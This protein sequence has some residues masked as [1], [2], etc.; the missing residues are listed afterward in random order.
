LLGGV[1][2]YLTNGAVREIANVH[3]VTVTGVLDVERDRTAAMWQAPSG[4]HGIRLRRWHQESSARKT[5]SSSE[6]LL[7]AEVRSFINDMA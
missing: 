5:S 7:R 6:I 2:E 1:D 3:P 4:G